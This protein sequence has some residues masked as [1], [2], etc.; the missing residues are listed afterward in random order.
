LTTPRRYG[1]KARTLPDAL[2]AAKDETIG[3][4]RDRVEALERQLDA[5]Q[6]EIRRRDILLANLVERV[7]QLEAPREPRDALQTADDE[8]EGYESARSGGG[9]GGHTAPLVVA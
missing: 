1:T 9:S 3:E 5:R 8:A 6:E 7:P 4:L 2:I